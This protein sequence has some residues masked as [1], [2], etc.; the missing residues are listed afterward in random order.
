MSNAFTASE[1]IFARARCHL[2]QVRHRSDFNIKHCDLI[3]VQK[4]L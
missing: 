2:K 3:T 4:K 1:S